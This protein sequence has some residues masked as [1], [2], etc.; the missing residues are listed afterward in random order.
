MKLLA[1]KV[2]FGL[3]DVQVNFLDMP[4]VILLKGDTVT[5]FSVPMDW[6]E[7]FKGAAKNF[8]DH[9]LNGSQ[10]DTDIDFSMQVLDT[11]LYI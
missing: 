9:L 6:I 3:T 2:L 5:S 8:I 4:P 11:A 7:G 1:K 10:P